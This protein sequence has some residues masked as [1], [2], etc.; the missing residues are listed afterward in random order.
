MAGS[1]YHHSVVYSLEREISAEMIRAHGHTQH[2][3]N[4]PFHRLEIAADSTCSQ[5]TNTSNTAQ[6]NT[7]AN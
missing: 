2:F 1:H 7:R 6:S 5:S 3:G 4:L